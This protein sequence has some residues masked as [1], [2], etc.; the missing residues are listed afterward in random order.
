METD[1]HSSVVTVT[2]AG[3]GGCDGL[4]AVWEQTINGDV[5]YWD[6]K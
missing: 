4:Y 1:T 5:G 6:L 3:E 2:L